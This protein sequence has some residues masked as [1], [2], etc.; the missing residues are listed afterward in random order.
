MINEYAMSFP[1]YDID[2][3]VLKLFL[4]EP[5]SF[6]VGDKVKYTDF[7]ARDTSALPGGTVLLFP[8]GQAHVLSDPGSMFVFR[9]GVM[10]ESFRNMSK[11]QP[12]YEVIHIP[13]VSERDSLAY[14]LYN[15]SFPSTTHEDARS[16]RD[17]CSPEFWAFR[18]ADYVLANYSRKRKRPDLRDRDKDH[19]TWVDEEGA[20]ECVNERHVAPR[21]RPEIEEQFGP[22]TEIG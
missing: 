6:K 1:T 14:E 8:D 12:I 10:P 3:I 5:L 16:F 2:P 11:T 20:Y 13:S 19:W 7:S 18:A 4:G 22:V 15:S 17:S 21:S 9:T